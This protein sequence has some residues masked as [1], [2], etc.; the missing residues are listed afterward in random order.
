MEKRMIDYRLLWS[1]LA[2][3]GRCV[4]LSTVLGAGSLLVS[5]QLKAQKVVVQQQQVTVE[6]FFADLKKQTGYSFLW[7]NA[8][9]DGKKSLDIRKPQQT[10]QG[11][12]SAALEGT[13]LSYR[14]QNKI[15]YIVRKN[16]DVKEEKLLL[17]GTVTTATG[18]PLSSA[19]IVVPGTPF[20]TMSDTTG[21]FILG[22]V[23]NGATIIVSY[24]GY[25][26]QSYKTTK[27]E[28][29]SFVLKEKDSGLDEV[30]IVGYG[31]TTKRKNTGAVSS[32]TS[33]IIERQPI[34]NPLLALQGAMPGVELTQDNGLPGAAV[35]VSIRG[36]NNTLSSGGSLPLYVI[37]GVPFT[38]FNG[39]SPASDNLNSYGSFGSNGGVSPFS[40]IAPE[41]I[42]RIDVLKD[43]DATAI[44][45]SR[46]ANGVI[47]IT[48]KKGSAGRTSVNVNASTGFGKVGAYIPMMNTEQYLAMRQEAFTNAS[49]TPTTTTAPDLLVWSQ[50]DYTDWQKFLIG[51][52]ARNSK[53]GT[54]I[55]G[56]N[57]NNT[58][59]FTTDYRNQGTVYGNDFNAQTFSN[60]L[61]AGH[62]SANG[63]F[64][65]DAS[66][67]YTYM[68]TFLPTTDLAGIYALAPNY[69]LYDS[70]G[71]LNWTSTNPLS[72]FQR[73]STNKSNNLI[74]NV[75]L[76]YKI[77][78]SLSVKL[79]GGYTKTQLK[80]MVVTPASAV[81]ST[82]T[83]SNSLTY[84]DN[85]NENYILEPQ[86]EYI[87]KISKGKLSALV[88]TTFQQSNATGVTLLGTG[89]ASASMITAIGNA[90]T[91]TVTY[92]NYSLY[93]YNAFFGRLNYD[94]EGK[95]LLNAT[96]R[97]DGSS[98]FGS[99]HKFGNFGAVGAAWIITEEH[100]MQNIPV[101]SFAKLRGSYGLTGN[102]Q[103]TDYR[104]ASTYSI[105]SSTYSYGGTT[106]LY[107]TN[108]PNPDLQWETVK[109]LDIGLELGFLKD[110]IMLKSDYYRNRQSKMLTYVTL[111]TQVGSSTY[112]G[113]LNGLV[114][115]KGF[116]F[117]LTTKNIITG[118]FSWTTSINWTTIN[119][120]LLDFK[121]K[122]KFYYSSSYVIGQPTNLKMAYHYIG[123]NATTGL[124]QFEDMDGDGSITYANDR[125]VA[126]Y[127]KPSF[128]GITN[129][130]SYCGVTLDFSFQ[131]VH[132]YGTKNATLTTNYNPYGYA[133]TNQSTALLDRWT[134]TNT[135]AYFPKASASY[136]SLYSTLAS[137]DYNW[138]DAS[139]L[140]LRNVN[141]SYSV[142]KK[143]L[144]KLNITNLSVY[145]QGQNL[146]T[147]KKQKFVYDPNTTVSGTGS[148]LGTGT[149]IALP[150]L[151][152][153]V[154]GINCS[155]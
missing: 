121:D 8:L 12:L 56:G 32:I 103:I 93:K 70:L 147:W 50:T 21:H 57:G 83:T 60:R 19:S 139:Y 105:G 38:L 97:R 148:S 27:S 63:R 43:A 41:D 28:I 46:G 150:Q 100:F 71:N 61:N 143:W 65:I 99:N 107:P 49:V 90:S 133:M 141:I 53:I 145:A 58:F 22:N 120:K 78:P 44:Y 117:E 6:Q 138:G 94:W 125:Y 122:D 48:T 85:S 136:S 81:N 91:V 134:S 3:Y 10:L 87:T 153:I 75:N 102:D 89:F 152:T 72:Y 79:N 14:I 95:Y 142:P 132:R 16:V 144:R 7:D 98:R 47:L 101:I 149:Y 25:L 29:L 31:K 15:V 126:K 30:V 131:Y 59:L 69:P 1:R 52:T 96:F 20:G 129:T 106:I 66:A 51:H 24:P 123:P 11:A 114:Q 73:T 77:L 88:G 74:T 37:D 67:S 42:L 113:N 82:S 13:N 108:I 9:L 124:P 92:N 116:E 54:T 146:Y 55:S 140:K 118:N 18:L 84:A 110:R 127:G 111:P 62:K 119:N 45:G 115:N 68:K 39:G 109:K 36:A 151:R 40:L 34:D 64:S 4:C 104:Y 33:D 137:S 23:P 26:D 5:P 17:Q 76:S 155:F 2:V 154:F 130:F 80:Q 135:D 112:L 86:A 128:G 35:R